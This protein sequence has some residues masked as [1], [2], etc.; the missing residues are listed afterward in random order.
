M[1]RAPTDDRFTGAGSERH[2][3]TPERRVDMSLSTILESPEHEFDDDD[4]DD[5]EFAT[6]DEGLD[7]D[8]DEELEDEDDI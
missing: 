7:L 2:P 3:T 6:D 8:E 4:W 5:E 1:M